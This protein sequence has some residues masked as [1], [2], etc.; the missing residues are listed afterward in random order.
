MSKAEPK[1]IF[2]RLPHAVLYEFKDDGNQ[3]TPYRIHYYHVG[4]SY[5]FRDF[6]KW[7]YLKSGVL[8]ENP[9]TNRLSIEKLNLFLEKELRMSASEYRGLIFD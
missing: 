4:E 2:L 6:E 3:D 1:L 5:N 8:N 7:E 9:Y